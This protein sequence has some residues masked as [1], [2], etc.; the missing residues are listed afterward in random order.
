LNGFFAATLSLH[1]S[2]VE[3]VAG[4]ITD[5]KSSSPG[6]DEVS[7][8]LLKIS[9][10]NTAPSIMQIVN[11]SLE[12][13]IYPNSLKTAKVI[14]IFKSGDDKAVNNYRPISLLPTVGK[15]TEKVVAKRLVAFLECSMIL[16]K[17]Q[18]GFRRG[19]SPSIA[20]LKTID[21]L[22]RNLDARN[23][24]VGVFLDLQKAF[25]TVNHDILLDKLYFYGI[26][27]VAH[28]WFR[29]YLDQRRQFVVNESTTSHC[30]VVQCGI[31]QGSI[32]GP[33]LFLLYINDMT[34]CSNVFKF[35]LF[36]DDTN[37]FHFDSNPVSLVNAVN[38]EL[39]LVDQ[40]LRAN[41][42]SLNL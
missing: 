39:C 14:P 29:S 38:S 21:D 5:M 16:N 9:V 8:F 32:L 1:L 10:K 13:G 2:C 40:W 24:G 28:K 20:I 22:I 12:T 34:K 26:R 7:A 19:H 33:I 27:G 41:K 37:I 25:D 31:P 6:Y 23:F 17:N 11:A 42:L 30:K 15:I 35:I 4:I 3:E 36:A 18:F